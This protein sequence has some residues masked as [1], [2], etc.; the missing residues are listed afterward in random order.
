MDNDVVHILTGFRNRAA[1]I[2]QAIFKDFRS[3]VKRLDRQT[4]ENVFQRLQARYLQ[5]LDKQL[6][7]IAEKTV[8]EYSPYSTATNLHHELAGQISYLLA[9]FLHKA[10]SM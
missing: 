5:E 8:K 10:K 7:Q 9:E 3:S 6:H 1:S 4:D 2:S